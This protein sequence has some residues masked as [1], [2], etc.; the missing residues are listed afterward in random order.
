M[1]S[2]DGINA[3]TTVKELDEIT[4]Y[5]LNG[6]SAKDTIVSRHSVGSVHTEEAMR[7]GSADFM[8][9]DMNDSEDSESGPESRGW[10][11][12]TSH[13]VDESVR[14][15]TWIFGGQPLNRTTIRLR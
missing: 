13:E 1:T 2:V 8:L 11:T 5:L 6:V 9:M 12:V 4:S 10:V 15:Q 7:S 14:L 3:H